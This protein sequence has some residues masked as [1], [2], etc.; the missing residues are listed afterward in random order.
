MPQLC[1]LSARNKVEPMRREDQT[2]F[3]SIFRLPDLDGEPEIS[4]YCAFV[5]RQTP[6]TGPPSHGKLSSRHE[7]SAVALIKA[8]TH[9]ALIDCEECGEQLSDKAAA[10]PKC[11]APLARPSIRG[12]K[13]KQLFTGIIA[14][15]LIIWVVSNVDERAA[16]TIP[17]PKPSTAPAPA[18]KSTPTPARTHTTTP[19][20]PPVRDIKRDGLTPL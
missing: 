17:S 2:V 18:P 12:Q 8:E 4:F 11:G 6:G 9:V 7:G 15:F 16:P 10:C 19:N 20:P 5:A 14:L 1:N 3:Y 13:V